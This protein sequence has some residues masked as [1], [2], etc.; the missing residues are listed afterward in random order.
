MMSSEK[1]QPDC[2]RKGR[3][4]GCRKERKG[5]EGGKRDERTEENKRRAARKRDTPI[6]VLSCGGF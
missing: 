1:M 6:V 2:R 4:S 5:G 3:E